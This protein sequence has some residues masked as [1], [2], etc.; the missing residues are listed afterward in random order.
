[1]KVWTPIETVWPV[2]A[3]FVALCGALWFARQLT[4]SRKERPW[5]LGLLVLA[6]GIRWWWLPVQGGIFQM[7]TRLDCYDRFAA[8]V[9]H[10]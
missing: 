9:E 5:M 4:I 8:L 10:W 1:M 7:G 2:W 6:F 3:L